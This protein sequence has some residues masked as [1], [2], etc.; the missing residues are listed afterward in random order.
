MMDFD[1][2]NPNCVVEVNTVKAEDKKKDIIEDKSINV[3]WKPKHKVISEM[4]ENFLPVCVSVLA[5]G[6]TFL[7]SNRDWDI[8]V[9]YLEFLYMGHFEA[10]YRIYVI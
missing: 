3:T 2:E 5:M 6:R 1:M 8:P 4:L 7:Q 9:G 10:R